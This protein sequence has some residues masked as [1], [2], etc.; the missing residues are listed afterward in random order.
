[1]E[2]E[3]NVKTVQLQYKKINGLKNTK[4]PVLI[5]F[6][7]FLISPSLSLPSRFSAYAF[8]FLFHLFFLFYSLKRFILLFFFIF[9]ENKDE[10]LKRGKDKTGRWNKK[11]KTRMEKL[12]R[13]R[14]NTA[15]RPRRKDKRVIDEYHYTKV[16]LWIY[17]YT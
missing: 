8:I 2:N 3:H 11:M 6:S 17:I 12:K 1:M 4:E 16:K 7:S 10:A 15:L 5:C 13:A 14:W 9:D